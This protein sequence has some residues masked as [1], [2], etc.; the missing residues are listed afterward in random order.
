MPSVVPQPVVAKLTRA[1]IFL[2]AT[3]N[4][5]K[6]SET[7]VRAL[8]ADLSALLRAVG[9]R[10]LEARLSCVMGIG[11]DAWD[12]LFGTPRPKEL[13]RFREIHGVHHA[14]STPGDLLFH[15]R[16]VRMDLCFEIASQIM[17]RL[18]DAV[19]TIDEVHG[20]KYFDDRDLLGFVDGT[21]NP[22]DEE[23][24]EAAVIGDEDPDFA[25]GSYVIVQKYLHDL[26]RWNAVPVAEQ[27]NIIG[28]HKLSDIEQDDAVKAP[29]AHNVLNVIEEDGKQLD[30]VR[31]N[32]PFGE[33][34]KGEF[35]TYFIGYARSP[36]RTEQMLENMFIGKP[37]GNYDRLLDFSRAA[38]GVL[39]FVPSAT[40]L[41]NVAPDASDTDS[42]EAIAMPG[43][44]M[45]A[46]DLGKANAPQNRA[47]RSDGSLGIGSLKEKADHE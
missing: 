19:T 29:Y 31:D 39:F 11:S 16:S 7:A 9:F 12:R 24:I 5:G 41:D 33:I 6:E 25:G 32:M 8:C 45:P 14:V 26:K 44:I 15:I 23:A 18:G 47:S 30:I 13:H 42:P 40:F 28:R 4:P 35:G 3:I 36:R 37:P 22:V 20:F 46:E 38:T 21:E 34:G 1:A 27:E 2:V 17:A 43:D 10:D